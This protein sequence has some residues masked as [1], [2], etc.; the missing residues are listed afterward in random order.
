MRHVPYH[1]AMITEAEIAEVVSTLRSGWLTNGPRALEF[2]RMVAGYKESAHA[3]A[4]SSC[5]DGLQLALHV[6][7][8]QPGD[9]VVTTPMT[10]AATANTILHAGGIPVFADIEAGTMN[11]SPSEIERRITPRTKAILPVHVGGNPCRMDAIMAI[12][13]QHGLQVIEDC[14][15]A[16]EG[17]FEGR[18]LGTFGMASSFSFYPTKNITT[19]EGG[20]VLCQ[21]EA[22][23][24]RIRRLSRHGL[25]KSTYQ[26]ME[27]EGTPL[28]DVLEPGYKMNLSDLQAGIGICQMGR[29]EEMYARRK[30]IKAVY[31][32]AFLAEEGLGCIPCAD[33][34]HPSLHLYQLLL[35]PKVF[36]R[37][38]DAFIRDAR[39]LGVEMSVNYTPVHL[40]SWYRNHLG[41]QEGDFPQAEFAGRQNIS[42]P[43]YP[44]MQDEDVQH[45][46]E[47]VL[48]LAQRA[49]S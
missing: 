24:A 46:V 19:A 6:L 2:E 39:E 41:T 5:T 49:K 48:A 18:H 12:A 42:L 17:K 21:D 30:E 7:D 22:L 23:A 11:I 29:V 16:L 3:I 47:V 20:M 35:D 14:A 33:G 32:A 13:Q 8:L 37:G 31:D 28:Y 1:R 4:V 9:E 26:R 34:G 10:F 40:F 25:D 44:A 43:F 36:S 27:V 15:H 45:V 38:R